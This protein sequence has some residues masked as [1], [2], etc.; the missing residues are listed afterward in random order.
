MKRAL[1]RPPG[2][3]APANPVAD[4]LRSSNL[5]LAVFDTRRGQYEG[6][7][8]DKLLGFSPTSAPVHVRVS[9]VGLAQAVCSFADSLAQVRPAAPM[10]SH[11]ACL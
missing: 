2:P 3:Q 6:E 1:A 11:H 5:V 8:H 7:E 4:F 9:L 10:S